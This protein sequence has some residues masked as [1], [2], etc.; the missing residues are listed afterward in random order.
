MTDSYISTSTGGTCFVG[1]DAT[2]LIRATMLKHAIKM[3]K[4]GMLIT[5]GMTLT[6]SMKM[7]TY[8]TGKTY[9]RGQADAAIADLQVWCDTMSMALPRKEG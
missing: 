8:Y 2:H 3:A 6:K 1:P 9:K 4:S 5:R 7:V